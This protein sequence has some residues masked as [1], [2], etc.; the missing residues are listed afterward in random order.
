MKRERENEK[1]KE[2]K[3]KRKEN[4]IKQRR[5]DWRGGDGRE[6]EKEKTKGGG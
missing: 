3:K 5:G 6:G 2:G 1:D 4:W